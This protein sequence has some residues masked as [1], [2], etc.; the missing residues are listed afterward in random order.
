[1][2][3]RQSLKIQ[4]ILD[5]N[6]AKIPCFLVE[7]QYLGHHVGFEDIYFEK[8]VQFMQA[9]KSL[10]KNRL[11][12]VLLD[13]GLRLKIWFVATYQGGL[14][15]KFRSEEFEPLFP[16]KCILEGSFPI[17]GEWVQPLVTALD[18][19]FLDGTPMVMQSS[20]VISEVI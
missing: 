1:M 6:I 11:G 8:P 10:E 9:L 18:K 17:D 7:I 19:L 4:R 3:T 5:E 14:N 20:L 12:G 13:G 2:H 16:G 15:I